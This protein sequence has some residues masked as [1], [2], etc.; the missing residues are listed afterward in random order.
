[1]KSSPP[2]KEPSR[3]KLTIVVIRRHGKIRSFQMSSRWLSLTLILFLALAA[4]VAL[5]TYQNQQLR[6]DRERLLAQVFLPKSRALAP[7]PVGPRAAA[8]ET[9]GPAEDEPDEAADK[10]DRAETGRKPAAAEPAAPK[11]SEPKAE[12]AQTS[13]TA[14]TEPTTTTTT[15]A[16]TTSSTTTTTA[17]AND[18]DRIDPKYVDISDVKIQVL[19]QPNGLRMSFKIL[20]EKGG[21]K[22]ISGYAFIVA[23]TTSGNKPVYKSYPTSAVLS[24]DRPVNHKQGVYFSIYQFKTIRGRIYD[25]ARFDSLDILVYD[26]TGRLVLERTLEV[27]GG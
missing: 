18:S 24:A 8:D 13:T 27:P 3:R 16:T 11:K 20:N 15:L 10:A 6:V 25:S 2:A 19:K 5:L 17:P 22:R 21:G 1:M 4:A 9:A 12:P 7:P 14:K 23:K 26:N